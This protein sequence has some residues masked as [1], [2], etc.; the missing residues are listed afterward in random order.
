MGIRSMSGFGAAIHNSSAEANSNA[1]V[2]VAV[3]PVARRFCRRLHVRAKE[4]GLS[5][6]RADGA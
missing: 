2:V 6:F 4:A 1:L 5:V 3:D